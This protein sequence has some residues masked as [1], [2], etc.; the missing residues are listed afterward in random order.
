MKKIWEKNSNVSMNKKIEN[1][2]SADDI[3]YDEQLALF[4]IYGSLAHLAGLFDLGVVNKDEYNKLKIGLIK[5]LGE[6]ME[7]GI[8]ISV[9]NEDIHTVIEKKL[10]NEIGQP[11]DKLHTCRSRN[12][13]VSVNLKLFSK[14]ELFGIMSQVLNLAKSFIKFGKNNKNVAMPGYT[15]MQKGMIS[16]VELWSSSFSVSLMDDYKLL[17]TSFNLN[18]QSPLGSAAGYGTP[19]KINKEL[20]AKKLG[21]YK[22]QDNYLYCQNSRGKIELAIVHALQQVALTINKFASDLM[23]FSMGEFGYFYLPDSFLTGSSI[24][25][26]KKNYDV[27]ELLRSKQAAISGNY[28]HL[29]SLISNLPSGYNRDFQEIKKP[30]FSSFEIIKESLVI[31]KE[32]ITHL[33][34]N[35]AL[36][37]K[38]ITSELL[39]TNEVYKLVEEGMSFKDAYKLIGNKFHN[40]KKTVISEYKLPLVN[41]YLL[42]NEIDRCK[43]LANNDY[44]EFKQYMNKLTI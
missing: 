38:S 33:M 4:D 13:Q 20:V 2:L 19:L 30:L 15:H 43:K 23:L 26:Q 27:L 8:N 44:Q 14:N 32:V 22:I 28:N 21:F 35:K 24:M 39:V 40:S 41:N 11:A 29:S 37:T 5:I 1:F 18:N 12:D 36:L 16:S 10:K 25:A 17:Q 42:I 7:N 6:S 3:I 31:T 34:V 9:E